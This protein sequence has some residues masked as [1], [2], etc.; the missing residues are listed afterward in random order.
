MFT[1]MC[2]LENSKDVTALLESYHVPLY[3]SGHLHLQRTNQHKEGPGDTG[4]GIYEIVS[5]AFSIPP[6]QY[7]ILEWQED[8][9]LQ[10]CTHEADVSAWALAHG[11]EDENLLGFPDY[12]EE[13]IRQV[14]GDQIKGEAKHVR[15]EASADMAKIYADAYADYCAGAE[16][17]ERE[18]MASR[19][20]KQ[21]VDCWPKS[22]QAGEL[23]AMVGDC[24][25]DYNVL[26]VPGA[27]K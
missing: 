15:K 9:D 3:I 2:T 12:K 21:W 5:D 23:R 20:Y 7:G 22:K 10:Y 24:S 13:Y 25:K 6:C 27:E 26:T 18:A 16:I 17:D 11:V 8:G 4:Y 14:I 1:T 19:E